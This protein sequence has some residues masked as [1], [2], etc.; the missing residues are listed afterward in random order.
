[1]N[2]PTVR[3]AYH[4]NWKRWDKHTNLRFS[5]SAILKIYSIMSPILSFLRGLVFLLYSSK[6]G[7][8]SHLSMK[9]LAVSS[10]G[11][12]KPTN[13]TAHGGRNQLNRI[14]WFVPSVSWETSMYPHDG[15]NR[16]NRTISATQGQKQT[17]RAIIGS[18]TSS[19]ES[20]NSSE[21]SNDLQRQLERARITY[22]SSRA[23]ERHMDD[24][25]SCNELS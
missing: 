8:L 10:G 11:R 24:Q 22:G 18:G 5:N 25:R 3:R 12:E 6:V 13:S 19:R 7:Y 4:T 17:F 15:T 9:L 1:M 2:M 21:A 20:E 23:S 14:S 16:Q